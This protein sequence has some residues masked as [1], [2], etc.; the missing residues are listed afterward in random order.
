MTAPCHS[1]AT[2]GVQTPTP[3]GDFPAHRETVTKAIDIPQDFEEALAQE[4]PFVALRAFA[5]LTVIWASC[6]GERSPEGGSSRLQCLACASAV[7]KVGEAR[8][9]YIAKSPDSPV[10]ACQLQRLVERIEVQRLWWLLHLAKGADDRTPLPTVARLST[11]F[12][13]AL[14]CLIRSTGLCGLQCTLGPVVHS[15]V[16]RCLLG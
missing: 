12:R 11:G 6:R 8:V 9:G 16:H 3:Q 5:S 15:G 4:H 7:S 1:D 13:N 10:R 14:L 2:G